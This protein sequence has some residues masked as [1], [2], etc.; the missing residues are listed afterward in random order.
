MEKQDSRVPFTLPYIMSMTQ[1]GQSSSCSATS[2]CYQPPL[3][4]QRQYAPP[5]CHALLFG[6]R[7]AH[8]QA[9]EEWVALQ[10]LFDRQ[11]LSLKVCAG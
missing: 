9:I 10:F 6:G 2:L 11:W 8:K 3:P 4:L 7:E 1:R 5:P